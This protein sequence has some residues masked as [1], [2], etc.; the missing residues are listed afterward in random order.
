MVLIPIIEKDIGN[1]V[2]SFIFEISIS[3]F[4]T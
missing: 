3:S 4:E 2:N 1:T